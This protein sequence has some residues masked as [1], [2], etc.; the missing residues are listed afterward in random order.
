MSTA[1]RSA[2]VRGRWAIRSPAAQRELEPAVLQPHPAVAGTGLQVVAEQP[3]EVGQDGR[4]DGGVQPVA[5]VVDPDAG[6]LEAG[7]HAPHD[8]RLVHHRHLGA[9]PG[10][11]PR[12]RQAGGP[13]AE[14]HHVGRPVHAAAPAPIDETL[15]RSALGARDHRG[16]PSR[17]R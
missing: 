2:V 6:H 11:L 4:V 5:A 12:R 14:D 1:A 8:G 15:P 10:R 3:T 7:C 16:L 9:G 13:G 17:S